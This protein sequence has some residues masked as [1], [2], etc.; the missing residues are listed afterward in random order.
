MRGW[1]PRPGHRAKRRAGPCWIYE[2]GF[3]G[4][5]NDHVFPVN[6]A[7]AAQQGSRY[8]PHSQQDVIASPIRA[9]LPA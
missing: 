6:P 9:M 8:L 1:G 2:I 7:F 5:V 3:H 4:I